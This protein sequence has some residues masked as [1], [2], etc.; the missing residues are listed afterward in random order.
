MQK[1]RKFFSW[2]IVVASQENRNEIKTF[3]FLFGNFYR[4]PRGRVE[5]IS[6][7]VVELTGDGLVVGCLCASL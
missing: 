1:E 3:Q 4:L 5:V 6:D 7:C 2:F